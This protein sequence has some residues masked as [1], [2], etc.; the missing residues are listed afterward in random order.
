VG[1][2]DLTFPDKRR[3]V[4]QCSADHG[5]ERRQRVAL[6][7]QIATD[8]KCLFQ[9]FDTGLDGGN[10]GLGDVKFPASSSPALGRSRCILADWPA[11]HGCTMLFR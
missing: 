9:F 4:I 10:A 7:T 6:L 1:A 5:G 11:S 2:R 3:D 8:R